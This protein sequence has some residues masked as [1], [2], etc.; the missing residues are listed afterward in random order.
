LGK[1]NIPNTLQPFLATVFV[2]YFTAMPDTSRSTDT[3]AA[4]RSAPAPTD[5][6]SPPTWGSRAARCWDLLIHLDLTQFH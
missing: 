1:N 5:C 3:S 4:K 6:F 2:S